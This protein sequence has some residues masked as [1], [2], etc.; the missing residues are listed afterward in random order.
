MLSVVEVLRNRFRKKEE[1]ISLA[2]SKLYFWAGGTPTPQE[3]LTIVEQAS[4]LFLRMTQ[5]VRKSKKE[6]CC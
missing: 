2:A 4:C 6:K 3:N 1:P 5:D